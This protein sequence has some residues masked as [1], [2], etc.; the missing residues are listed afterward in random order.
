LF[1]GKLLQFEA[2]YSKC[3]G[4]FPVEK[5]DDFGTL[6]RRCEKGSQIGNVKEESKAR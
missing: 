4:K 5:C 6:N 2:N 3:I 1:F